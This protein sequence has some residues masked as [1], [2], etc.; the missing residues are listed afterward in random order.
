MTRR[1]LLRTLAL[2]YLFWTSAVVV[3]HVLD[4]S[5]AWRAFGAGLVLPGAG[6]LYA[7]PAP[8]HPQSTMHV[9]GH[10]VFVGLEVAAVLWALRRFRPAVGTATVVS[11]LLLCIGLLAAP[12]TV[13]VVG[14]VVAFVSVLA[15]CAWAYMFRLVGWADFVTLPAVVV[16]SAVAGAAL[17]TG[18]G[19][20]SERLSW[21]PWIAL[22]AVLILSAAL[23]IRAQ[24]VHRAGLA[25]G[26]DRHRHLEGLTT[27]V[28]ARTAPVALDRSS[29]E[30][31]VTEASQ[32]EL[33]LLRHL[34]RVAQQPVDNW[35][36]YD[37]ELALPLGKYRYQINA[38]G[39][40]LSTFG[41]AHT[42]SY[43]GALLDAQVALIDRLQDRRVWGYWYWQNLLGNLDFIQRRADPIDV[44]QNIMFTGYLNLQLGMFRHA[45]GDSRYDERESLLFEWS[46]E[47]RYTFDHPRLNAIV[48]RNF[49][50]ELC[51]WPCEPAPFGRRRKRG[52]VFPYCNAVAAAGLGVADTVRGTRTAL[53]VAPRLED[54][55]AREFTL[56]TGDLMGFVVA[57][58]GVSARGIMTG[59]ATTAGIAAF[60]APLSPDLAWRS[61]HNLRREW[62]ETGAFQN[63]GS[64][65]RENPD[66]GTAQKTNAN[67]LVG[68]MMLA[69]ECGEREWHERLWSA[70]LEQLSFQEDDRSPGVWS[71]GSGSVHSNGMLGFAGFSQD[72]L[73][74]DMMT[75]GRRPE[76]TEGPRLVEVPTPDVLVAKA[77]SDGSGLDVVTYPGREPGRFRMRID[78]LRPGQRYVAHGAVSTDVEADSSGELTVEVDLSGRHSFNLRPVP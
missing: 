9:A 41:Y 60:L 73:L 23:L 78:R 6:L 66:W 1:W 14:H 17:T 65:G 29:G 22:V 20:Q 68:A 7:I 39:W 10:A 64:V 45:T 63:P 26:S 58:A 46:R 71:F 5:P 2:A 69:R 53:D 59:T 13:V 51:L 3:P 43:S 52:F 37:K 50:E 11:I 42:P 8:H 62:L 49:G 61:W 33:R 18:H 57:G 24:L 40:A 38:L 47:K 56:S 77:V 70:A 25:V 54:A 34:L 31:T 44:P 72:P 16:S 21:I 4:L 76:W 67:A 19:S 15:A 35:E 48:A 75:K 27:P 28:G 36:S 12:Y 30:S 55:L 32:D 74:T